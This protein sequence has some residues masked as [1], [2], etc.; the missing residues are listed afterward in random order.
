MI[1]LKH[2]T[3]FDYSEGKKFIYIFDKNSGVLY[4]KD[5]GFLIPGRSYLTSDGSYFINRFYLGHNCIMVEYRKTPK[6]L[7]AMS[8]NLFLQFLWIYNIQKKF[9]NLY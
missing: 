8:L 1:T 2:K 9:Q 4:T 6:K 7:H 3:L 5:F